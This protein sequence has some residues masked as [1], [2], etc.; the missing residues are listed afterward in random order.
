MG[1]MWRDIQQGAM[2]REEEAAKANP[3][4]YRLSRTFPAGAKLNRDN[5]ASAALPDGTFVMVVDEGDYH[6]QPCFSYMH[7]Q[8]NKHVVL[9]R[10]AALALLE[11]Q[12]EAQ[13]NWKRYF[14]PIMTHKVTGEC[15]VYH[16]IYANREGAKARCDVINTSHRTNWRCIGIA[17][18]RGSKRNPALQTELLN[19]SRQHWEA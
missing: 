5:A 14:T 8:G 7:D 17:A 3:R 4:K 6:G 11:G 12:V 18:I 19:R 15:R 2:K 9:S 10:N 1:S 16:G 13:A